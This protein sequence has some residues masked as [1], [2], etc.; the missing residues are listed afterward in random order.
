LKKVTLT[1]ALS[2]RP[3]NAEAYSKVL[4]SLFGVRF[5][6][7]TIEVKKI[8]LPFNNLRGNLTCVHVFLSIHLVYLLVTGTLV[9]NIGFL[10]GLTQLCLS[11]NSLRGLNFTM[12]CTFQQVIFDVQ[13]DRYHR[14]SGFSFTWTPCYW[15]TTHWKVKKNDT[16]NRY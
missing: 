15:I 7:S 3:P 16:K 13:Q 9:E 6:F 11:E 5:D 1:G 12:L 14:V 10:S 4:S 2:G 8:N